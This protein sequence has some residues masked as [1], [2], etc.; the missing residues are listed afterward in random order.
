MKF[1][2]ISEMG[3]ISEGSV[4]VDGEMNNQNTQDN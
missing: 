3:E 2:E 1:D 4:Y